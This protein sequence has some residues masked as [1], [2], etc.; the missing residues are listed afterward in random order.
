MN[1]II[2]W[3]ALDPS[4]NRGRHHRRT[5]IGYVNQ[6]SAAVN[7]GNV[8]TPSAVN[9]DTNAATNTPGDKGVVFEVDT[10][11]A[12]SPERQFLLAADDE[13]ELDPDIEKGPIGDNPSAS[14]DATAH[15]PLPPSS[16][17]SKVTFGSPTAL[18]LKQQQQQPKKR[19]SHG[20][21]M[22]T[23]FKVGTA[24]SHSSPP[25]PQTMED[26]WAGGNSGG[27]GNWWHRQQR[28]SRKSEVLSQEDPNS[29]TSGGGGA[30][31]GWM[32]WL[33]GSGVATHKKSAHEFP[34]M[35]E[36]RRRK[37]SSKRLPHSKPRRK[38]SSFAWDGGFMNNKSMVGA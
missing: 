14:V 19:S 8:V 21:G 31:V 6:K 10:P 22:R 17:S 7:R 26:S 20:S 9:A 27:M 18:Q 30:S 13:E 32:T 4:S 24:E 29:G 15:P 16:Q 34:S 12:T 36:K 5:S 23:L 33:G 38:K 35:G 1:W 3:E 2:P 28:W 11:T 37:V 25:T